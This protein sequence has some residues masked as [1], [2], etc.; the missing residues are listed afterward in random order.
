MS[1]YLSPRFNHMIFH[2][3][4]CIF[5]IYRYSIISRGEYKNWT[6]WLV[7]KVIIWC[8]IHPAGDWLLSSPSLLSRQVN[9]ADSYW[10]KF[11]FI[12]KTSLQVQDIWKDGEFSKWPD[13]CRPWTKNIFKNWYSRRLKIVNAVVALISSW[14]DQLTEIHFSSN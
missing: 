10:L 12:R 1:S 6:L 13:C 8:C 7:E 2:I 4:T 3:F 11:S 5:T 9:M 14:S